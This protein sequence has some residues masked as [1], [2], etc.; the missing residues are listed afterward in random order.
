SLLPAKR[1][2]LLSS[3]FNCVANQIG[4]KIITIEHDFCD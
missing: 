4:N 2:I 1:M 3:Y